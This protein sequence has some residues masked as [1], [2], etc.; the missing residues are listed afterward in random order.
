MNAKDFKILKELSP[1]AQLRVE[2]TLTVRELLACAK[3]LT[4]STETVP[5]QKTVSAPTLLPA[6]KENKASVA[7]VKQKTEIAIPSDVI[8]G[9]TPL[10]DS[11]YFRAKDVASYYEVH[12]NSVYMW[13]EK[14]ILK[15]HHTKKKQMFF[16]KSDVEKLKI[17][18]AKR[19]KFLNR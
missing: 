4:E 8:E 2:L 19:Q 1:E 3:S 6:P 12:I 16:S 17:E 13:I 14:G 7:D 5:T 9:E 10:D 15:P 11:T 18:R